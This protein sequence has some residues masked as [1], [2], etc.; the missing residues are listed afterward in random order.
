MD[1]YEE[2]K[3]IVEIFYP[4]AVRACGQ[5]GRDAGLLQH[6]ILA[7]D[8]LA[9]AAH[10]YVSETMLLRNPGRL[11]SKKESSEWFNGLIRSSLGAGQ[12]A[13][14]YM[15]KH[16]GAVPESVMGFPSCD[17]EEQGCTRLEAAMAKTGTS[18]DGFVTNIN[19]AY[20]LMLVVMNPQFWQPCLK[21]G[22]CAAF[23]AGASH[24]FGEALSAAPQASF[25]DGGSWLPRP[26]D[27]FADMPDERLKE[28]DDGR[29]FTMAMKSFGHLASV[30]GMLPCG[31]ITAEEFF[32]PS[33]PTA[34]ALARSESCVNPAGTAFQAGVAFVLLES[35]LG[36][37]QMMQLTPEDLFE[38]APWDAAGRLIA[39]SAESPD[40]FQNGMSS[41]E[42][43]LKQQLKAGDPERA[44]VLRAAFMTGVSA[45]MGHSFLRG[46]EVLRLQAELM[47]QEE[48]EDNGPRQ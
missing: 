4:K 42:G 34:Q 21:A 13:A 48:A 25:P 37:E 35:S 29:A 20:S 5:I 30:S 36:L 19:I 10:A 31:S 32:F 11:L 15:L 44:A 38:Q 8:R 12:V 41:L 27:A 26:L 1:T 3:E 6:G 7:T 39:C 40:K 16:G 45:A 24:A 2:Q 46:A 43:D 9:E 23:H 33:F 17:A 18:F 22:M 47:A 28:R 14:E